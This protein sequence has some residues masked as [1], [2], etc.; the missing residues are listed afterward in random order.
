MHMDWGNRNYQLTADGNQCTVEMSGEQ[1]MKMLTALRAV[2]N[3]ILSEAFSCAD[4]PGDEILKFEMFIPEALPPN[5]E[6]KL[7]ITE[8]CLQEHPELEPP[9][10][11]AREIHRAN[12]IPEKCN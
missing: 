10:V 4:S 1:A 12:G 8:P 7:T 5:T 11:A 2:E 3:T 6:A 9:L